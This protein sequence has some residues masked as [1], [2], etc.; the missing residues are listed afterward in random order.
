MNSMAMAIIIIIII[1]KQDLVILFTSYEGIRNC[2]ATWVGK[3]LCEFI[4]MNI[5]FCTSAIIP[6]SQPH[7]V[8][9]Y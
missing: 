4:T 9:K 2:N 5:I 8:V 7:A 1:K 3:C 6:Y